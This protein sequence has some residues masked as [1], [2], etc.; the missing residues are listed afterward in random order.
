MG[1][2]STGNWSWIGEEAM[3]FERDWKAGRRPRIED[4]LA[5]REESHRTPV[6]EDL[7]RVERE[8]L[9]GAGERLTD[10]PD[11]RR[12]PSLAGSLT[13]RSG[14][15]F[16]AGRPASLATGL[17]TRAT[18]YRDKSRTIKRLHQEAPRSAGFSD[19][20]GRSGG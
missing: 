18:S 20:R 3:R 8:L 9:Q 10:E 12:F 17:V 13:P 4:F 15:I 6:L 7:L 16:G 5:R 14:S 2:I 1:E 19:F 11:R